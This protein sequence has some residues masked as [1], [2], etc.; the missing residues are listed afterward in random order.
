MRLYANAQWAV[1]EHGLDL[2]GE[3]A[4]YEIDAD[5]L[6]ENVPDRDREFYL[7]PVQMA[8]KPWVDL[9]LFIDAFLQALVYHV[10]AYPGP[11]NWL[12]LRDTI[13]HAWVVRDAVVGQQA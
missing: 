4:P 5:R 12:H 1:T 6:S 10:G 3:H 13:D 2:I 7:W 11:V 9:G 8:A